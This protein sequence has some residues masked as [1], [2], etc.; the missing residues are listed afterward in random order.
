MHP[1]QKEGQP[2]MKTYIK[3]NP[4]QWSDTLGHPVEPIVVFAE[5]ELK[6]NE[7]LRGMSGS[8]AYDALRDECLDDGGW[9]IIRE[10]IK[11]LPPGNKDKP[12]TATLE[13]DK[14][15]LRELFDS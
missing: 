8:R 12:S 3:N 11:C 6:A 10:T 13:D 9:D 2:T 7:I 15:L 4:N 1:N 5:D 14:A